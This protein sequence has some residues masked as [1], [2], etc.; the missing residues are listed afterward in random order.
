MPF[1]II[2]FVIFFICIVD[3]IGIHY[4]IFPIGLLFLTAV[5]IFIILGVLLVVFYLAG[6][7]SDL[8]K[9]NK[10]GVKNDK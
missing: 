7:I 5:T 1:V 10:T 3:P 2:L 6:W 8:I 9:T 4:I